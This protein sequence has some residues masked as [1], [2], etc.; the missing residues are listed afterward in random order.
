M[1]NTRRLRARLMTGAVLLTLAGGPSATA[2]ADTRPDYGRPAAPA[3]RRALEATINRLSGQLG[4]SKATLYAI[5][6]I[7]STQPKSLSFEQIVGLVEEKAREAAALKTR[8]SALEVRLASSTDFVMRDRG[9]ALLEDAG[10]AIDEGRLLDADRALAALVDLRWPSTDNARDAWAEAVNQRVALA[11]VRLDEEAAATLALNAFAAEKRFDEVDRQKSR[12]RQW[13]FTLDAA[14]AYAEKGVRLVDV[15]SLRRAIE[16]Y[17][18]DALPLT[19]RSERPADWA[20][21]QSDLAYALASLGAFEDR[22]E[23]LELAVEA[24]HAALAERT[25]ERDPAGW[26]ETQGRLASALSMLGGRQAGVER[27]QESYGIYKEVLAVRPQSG[28]ALDQATMKHNLGVLLI[29]LGQRTG[30]DAMLREAVDTFR[31]VLVIYARENKPLM[32]AETQNN[33]GFALRNLGWR[34]SGTARLLES[35][36]AFRAALEVQTREDPSARWA[37]TRTSLGITLTELGRREKSPARLKEAVAL[38]REALDGA[39]RDPSRVRWAENQRSLG[40]ALWALGDLEPG[41]AT[42][43]DGRTAYLAALGELTLK[44]NPASWADTQLY[45]SFLLEK[46][47]D[48]TGERQW[49]ESAVTAARQAGL[50][51]KAAAN[52]DRSALARDRLAS[53]ESR[54]RSLR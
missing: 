39:S 37:G 23:V 12:E 17:R 27:L 35:E 32:W 5:A 14:R 7:V 28:S 31:D 46:L 33:L 11:R 16:I 22:V 20:K 1:L 4:V 43:L 6:A 45:L 36:A 53:L 26:T 15:A 50:G 8:V 54:R 10:R 3:K 42:L 52:A 9:R 13:R 24:F 29:Q 51:F 41:T 2:W 49:L 34:D 38:L 21:T 40:N 18:D 19:P 47:F 25:Y 44:Q 30:R 48:R